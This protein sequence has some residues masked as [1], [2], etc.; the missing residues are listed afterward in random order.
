VF[1]VGLI[2]TMVARFLDPGQSTWDCAARNRREP[3][4]AG[5][6]GRA[7]RASARCILPI[8]VAMIWPG[9]LLIIRWPAGNKR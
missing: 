8:I 2:I 4:P 3:F 1:M 9:N 5:F 6:A 7:L